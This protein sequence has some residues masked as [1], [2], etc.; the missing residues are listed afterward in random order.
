[1]TSSSS[2]RNQKMKASEYSK[3]IQQADFV[4]DL[5]RYEEQAVND[6]NVSFEERAK[7]KEVIA[8]RKEVLIQRA[9]DEAR[10]SGL[11]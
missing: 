3:I 11:L 4:S 2:W 10:L 1:M 9:R 8:E 7:L 6:R 5:L